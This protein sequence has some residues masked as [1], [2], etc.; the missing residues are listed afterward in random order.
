M[1]FNGTSWVAV[2]LLIIA[3]SACHGCASHAPTIQCE[4]YLQAINLGVPP[5]KPAVGN[6]QTGAARSPKPANSKGQEP[7]P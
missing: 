6:A 7:S 2:A 5:Q 1:N 4:K 3:L